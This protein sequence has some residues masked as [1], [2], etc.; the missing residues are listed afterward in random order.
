MAERA[1][2]WN[3]NAVMKKTGEDEYVCPK[4]GCTMQA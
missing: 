4:C 1:R 2:C 3:C